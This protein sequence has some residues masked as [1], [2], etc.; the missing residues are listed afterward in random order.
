MPEAGARERVLCTCCVRNRASCLGCRCDALDGAKHDLIESASGS[1]FES[2]R[3]E[4]GFRSAADAAG[5]Q[6][7]SLSKQGVWADSGAPPAI[8][9]RRATVDFPSPMERRHRRA[10]SRRVA[11]G[12]RRILPYLAQL[13]YR[14]LAADDGVLLYGDRG[15]ARAP[16]RLPR[17]TPPPPPRAPAV[18]PLWRRFIGSSTT[19][20]TPPGSRRFGSASPSG[21]ARSTSGRTRRSSSTRPDLIVETGTYLGGSAFYLAGICDLLGHG[22]IVTV[23]ISAPP[24]RPRHRRITYLQGSSTD[25]GIVDRVARSARRA[26]RVMVVLDSNHSRDHVLRELEVYGP[27]V[28]PGCYL[29][30][31]DTNVNGNPVLPDHGPGP[32]EAVEE[33]LA[34]T[35]G[36]EVDRSRENRLLTFNPSGYLRRR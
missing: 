30:V 9:R 8:G 26:N 33:F 29:V 31:E 28:T 16:S 13:G 25:P 32:M 11:G 34:T 14:R 15:G 23:D 17:W 35:D 24:G 20:T 1:G 36:F 19:P 12:D 10:L 2:L 21:N 27:L 22:K 6:H 7:G 3:F 4:P 5:G 18:I